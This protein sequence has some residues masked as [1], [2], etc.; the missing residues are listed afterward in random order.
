MNTNV[1]A[2]QRLYVKMGGNPEDVSD[3]TTISEMIDEITT[4]GIV[5][6]VARSGNYITATTAAEMDNEDAIYVY[7][8]SEDGYNQG[9]LYYWDGTAFVDGGEY[10]GAR[11]EIDPTLS[12]TGKAADAKETGDAIASLNGSLEN[13]GEACITSNYDG[14]VGVLTITKGKGISAM[15]SNVT[16]AYACRTTLIIIQ[17]PTVLIVV[18][19]GYQYKIDVFTQSSSLSGG[20]LLEEG[21]MGGV[22]HVVSMP[23]TAVAF[24]LTFFTADKKTSYTMTDTDAQ[25]IHD[26]LGIMYEKARSQTY[27]LSTKYEHMT[28]ESTGK[29]SD[30]GITA[31]QFYTKIRQQKY[32]K[33]L[34]YDT[35]S[36]ALQTGE[37]ATLFEYGFD[38]TNVKKTTDIATDTPIKLSPKT[39]YIKFLV[40]LASEERYAVDMYRT[41][42]V[43]STQAPTLVFNQKIDTSRRCIFAVPYSLPQTIPEGEEDDYTA[44]QHEVGYSAGILMLPDTY[45]VDGNPTRLIIFCHSSGYYFDFAQYEFEINLDIFGYFLAEGYAVFDTYGHSNFVTP[46]ATKPRVYGNPDNM[47]CYSAGYKWVIDNYNIRTDGVYVSGKSLGGSPAMNIT[48]GKCGIPVKACG[49]MAPGLNFVRK[50]FGY[51]QGDRYE[52]AQAFGLTDYTDALGGSGTI[53]SVLARESFQNLMNAQYEKFCA[54]VPFWENTDGV[55]NNKADFLASAYLGVEGTDVSTGDGDVTRWANYSKHCDV[56]IKIWCAVDDA[57]VPYRANYNFVHMLKNG[58]S[59]AELRTLK[60][61]T[62][63]HSAMNFTE[64]TAEKIGDVM[65]A[66]GVVIS[67][68][69]AAYYELIQFFRRFQ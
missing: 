64:E 62:G 4:I 59:M 23:D 13:L 44:S 15:G 37:T 24:V 34:P 33:V 10:N 8:G 30:R 38:M 25:T 67:G 14:N 46:D 6:K 17:A 54:W 53:A 48:F 63:G 65:T 68:V 18:P 45:T 55:L 69:T 52:N 36:I 56:P 27:A 41:I 11:A 21:I 58:G 9:H 29:P 60:S 16:M 19:A 47:A 26:G 22:P 31:N 5:D 49:L 28:M 3:K 1:E 20:T 57:N 7:T 39:Y 61:G 43:V 51:N 40:S 12:H 42:S 66:T 35:V 2:L 50:G 32:I